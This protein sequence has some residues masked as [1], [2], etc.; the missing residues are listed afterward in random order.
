MLIPLAFLSIAKRPIPAAEA[1]HSAVYR[2]DGR[3]L[4]GTAASGCAVYRSTKILGGYHRRLSTVWLVGLMALLGRRPAVL[5]VSG[6]RLPFKPVILKC[7]PKNTL[8]S[9]GATLF[10][11]LLPIGLML[12][13]KTVAELN[14]AKDGTLYAGVSYR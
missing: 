8:P 12:S 6:N 5:K 3:P 9:L 2:A 10:T 11:V 4:R 7:A 14:M 13:V 1:G